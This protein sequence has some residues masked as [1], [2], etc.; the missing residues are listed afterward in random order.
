MIHQIVTDEKQKWE[1]MTTNTRMNTRIN[2][3]IR[4]QI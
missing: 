4:N 2:M 3:R 1:N